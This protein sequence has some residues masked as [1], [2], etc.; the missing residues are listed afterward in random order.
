MLNI[1][2]SNSI[3]A[4]RL[5]NVISEK[6]KSGDRLSFFE[7]KINAYIMRTYYWQMRI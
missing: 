3:V 5:K 1:T 6:G 2:A 4:V 7:N